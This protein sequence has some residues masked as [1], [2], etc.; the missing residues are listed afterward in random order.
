MDNISQIASVKAGSF[1]AWFEK[2][3][4]SYEVQFYDGFRVGALKF[5]TVESA[6]EFWHKEVIDRKSFKHC[7]C[8]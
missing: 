4:D 5:D 1:Q 6:R 8:C 2:V 7:Y 3:N